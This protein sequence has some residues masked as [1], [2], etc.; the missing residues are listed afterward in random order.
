MTD[1]PHPLALLVVDDEPK[2]VAELADAAM[3]EGYTVHTAGSGIEALA[4]LGREPG[5]GVIISDIRMPGMDGIT[6]TRRALA[7]RSEAEAVEVILITGHATLE[8][9]VAALRL[10]ACDFVRKPFRLSE[11]FDAT[12]L[13][14][15]RALGR[16]RLA[17][18]GGREVPALEGVPLQGLLGELRAPMVP[19]LGFAELLEVPRSPAETRDFARQIREG[20]SLLMTTVG[21]LLLLAEL[22]GATPPPAAKD[23]ALAPFLAARLSAVAGFAAQHGVSLVAA[24]AEADGLRGEAE[25]LARALEVLLRLAIR[26]APRGGAVRLAAQPRG[27]A[28]A[29]LVSVSGPRGGGEAPSDVDPWQEAR[30][31]APLGLRLVEAVAARHGGTLA[32]GTPPEAVF[33]AV[34]TLPGA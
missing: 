23:I 11:I 26:R 30:H 29:F 17:A 32:L 18:L 25:A 33:G 13:A 34:L 10:G 28:V 21:D 15:A 12:S 1:S 20:A 16:R 24:Q 31:A 14:M 9:A 8:D 3:D 2:V 7:E 19:I 22:E 6:L 5:I 4:L 27:K